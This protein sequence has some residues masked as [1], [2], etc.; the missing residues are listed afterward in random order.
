MPQ[1]LSQLQPTNDP[2]DILASFPASAAC[3]PLAVHSIPEQAEAFDDHHLTPRIY[4]ADSGQG[5]RWYTVGGRT[6]VLTTAPRMIEMYEAGTCFDHCRWEGQRGRCVQI[7]FAP[8]DLEAMTHGAVRVAIGQTRHELFDAE[9]SHL[10]LE[11]A[12]QALAGFGD[13]LLYAQGLSMALV[14]L[15]GARYSG[16]PMRQPATPAAGA[17]YSCGRLSAVQQRRVEELVSGQLAAG[18]SLLQLA[19][20][21]GLSMFHFARAFKA[22]FGVAPHQYVVSRR[23]QAAVGALQA[24][25]GKSIADI[26]LDCGFSS[27]AHLTSSMRKYLGVTPAQLRP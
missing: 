27:Q 9:V 25:R 13:G 22:T 24:G 10:A 5:K 6:R 26:A 17:R 19:E 12:R 23:L 3:L 14:G 4:V 15:V 7:E 8:A 21:A 16:R 11:L 1:D 18:P 20:A 2:A